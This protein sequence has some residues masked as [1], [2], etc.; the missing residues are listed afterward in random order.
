MMTDARSD[1]VVRV[2]EAGRASWP[3]IAIEEA[4]LAGY[5]AGVPADA[6]PERARDLFLAWACLCGHGAALEALEK[7]VLSQ[8]PAFVQRMGLPPASVDEVRQRVRERLLLGGA[9]GSPRLREYR[10]LGSLR[11][12]VRVIAV[13]TALD[14]RRAE[15]T[16]KQPLEDRIYSEVISPAASPELEV[17]RAQARPALLAAMQ[18]SFAA[19]APEDRNLLRLYYRD[20]LLLEQ[21]GAVFRV[22]TSTASRWLARL[23]QRLAEESTRRLREELHLAEGEAESLVR[24]LRSRIDVTL[25]Q[26]L[27]EP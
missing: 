23:R 15:T 8:V 26:L 1:L 5:L 17:L 13:R 11:N 18:A 4:E 25:S 20:G 9:G 10:G 19:L 21:I 6:P 3:E 16:G 27:A 2:R 22:H 24:A 14:L 7:E 12:W